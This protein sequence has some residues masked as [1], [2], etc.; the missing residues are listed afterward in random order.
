MG[1]IRALWGSS[2]PGPTL[3][4]T[5]LALA[6]GWAAGLDPARIALLAVAV[7]AGQLSVGISNDAIDAPRDRRTA[8]RD[9]PIARGDVSLR[10]VWAAAFLLLVAALAVSAVLGWR[11]LAAH[12][13]ALGSAW[14]YN[15]GLKSTP[16]SIVPFLVSF[17]IFPSLATLSAAEPVFAPLWAWIAGAALGA[18]IHLTNVL[19]DLDDDAVTGVRGLPHRWGPRASTVV[20]AAAVVAGAAAV[21]IGSAGGDL[22]A[23]TPVSWVFFAAVTAVAAATVVLVIL[24][25]P[26]RT[27]FRLVMLA[28]L[29]LAAQL[30]ATGSALVG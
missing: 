21:L 24:R 22:S 29:L 8:R 23:I 16:A 3:V 27:L 13:L 7:F 1:T 12:A 15:A 18:A 26:S 5:A 17:G 6:L 25:S 4:V 20:A 30:V 10:V 14:A 9:K 11:M 19:P 2:H 28:G